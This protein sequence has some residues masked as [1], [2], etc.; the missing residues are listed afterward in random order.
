MKGT[1]KGKTIFVEDPND[2]YHVYAVEWTPEKM[3]FLVDGVVYNHIENEHK[4]T[5]EWPFDQKFYLILNVAVGGMWGGQK[6]IDDSIFPQQMVVD[7][8]RVYQQKE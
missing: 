1:Q 4:T 3:D 5:A 2:T 7:Y 6:G 8:V